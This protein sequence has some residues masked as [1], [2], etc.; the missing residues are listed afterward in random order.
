MAHI[1][2]RTDPSKHPTAL[3]IFGPSGAVVAAGSLLVSAAR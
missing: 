1:G 3:L 2:G